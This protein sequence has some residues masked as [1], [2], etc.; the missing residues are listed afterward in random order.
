[1]RF[2][3]MVKSAE[4]GRAG[5]PPKEL[6]EAIGKLGAEAAEAGVMVEMGG[7]LPT[8]AGARV[9][10]AGGRVTVTDGPF[11]EAKEVVGGYAVYDVKSKQEAIEWSVRFMDLHKQHWKGWEGEVEIRQFMDR[12]GDCGG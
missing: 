9:T 10:L 12:P 4:T 8:A 11:T 5:P 3:T 1:M 2:I 7:L 6:M